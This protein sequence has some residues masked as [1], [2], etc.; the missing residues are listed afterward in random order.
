MASVWAIYG[1]RQKPP[2]CWVPWA[3]CVRRFELTD[4]VA[5]DVRPRGDGK[6]A[7]RVTMLVIE[8]ATAEVQQ[9]SVKPGCYASPL[10]PAKIESLWEE[11]RAEPGRYFVE[12]YDS[13]GIEAEDAHYF[14]GFTDAVAFA[15][16]VAAGGTD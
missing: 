9:Y 7:G 14:P 11:L 3:D 1:E 8:P 15:R 2:R 4:V 13:R 12:I 16:S 5:M 6:P 10:P